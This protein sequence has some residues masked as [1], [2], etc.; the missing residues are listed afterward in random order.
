MGIKKLNITIKITKQRVLIFLSGK[1]FMYQH[2]L[3]SNNPF[4]SNKLYTFFYMTKILSRFGLIAPVNKNF[5]Y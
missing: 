2:I 3:K 4:M 5:G 1:I